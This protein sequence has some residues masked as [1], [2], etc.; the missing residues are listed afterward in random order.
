L[1]RSRFG[2]GAKKS[3]ARSARSA[4]LEALIE[5]S[6]EPDSIDNG[7]PAGHDS[8]GIA[9]AMIDTVEA[10]VRAE[11]IDFVQLPYSVTDRLAE[12]RLL[13]AAADAGVAVLVMQPFDS[14]A[15]F[16]RVKGRPVPAWA[17]EIDC[18]SWAQVFLKFLLG[19]PAVTCPIPATSK[20][21]HLED[22]MGALR[23][24]IPDAALRARIVRELET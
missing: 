14:G 1:Q 12:K 21:K 15:L 9:R 24:R 17:A 6:A 10:I 5:E 8:S 4:N 2:I 20:I 3:P 7:P 22:N 13:P 18:T 11:T 19:H 23:G 16:D